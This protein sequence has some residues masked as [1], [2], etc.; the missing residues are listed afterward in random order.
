MNDHILDIRD[1][2]KAFGDQQVLRGVNIGVERGRITVILG[3]SGIGKSVL[4]KTIMG[5]LKPDSGEILYEGRDVV[6][7]SERELIAMRRDIG[8]LFQEAAL[9]DS[10][11]VAENIAF[12]LEE[13]LRWKDQKKIAARV[14]ELLDIVDLPDTGHKYPSELSGGMRKRVGLARALAASPKIVLFDEPP[15]GLAPRLS[16]NIDDLILKVNRQLGVTC[17]I[18]SHDVRAAFHIADTVAFLH[19]GRIEVCGTPTEV[20]RS[21]HPLFKLFMEQAVCPGMEEE[22]REPRRTQW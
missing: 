6:K 9:F 12:P 8:Y 14:A 21:E 19:E 18:I 5:L 16:A 1:V 7:M 22:T 2:H 17:L 4:F 11:T 20:R 15:P 3:K 13:M 10:L